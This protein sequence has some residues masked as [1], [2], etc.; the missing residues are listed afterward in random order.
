MRVF[1]WQADAGTAY[2]RLRLPLTELAARGH[3]AMVAERMPDGVQFAAGADVVVASRTC[4]PGPSA[5]FQ[6][7]AAEDRMLCVFE[8]D[9]DLFAVTPD[10][11]AHDY[12]HR[13]RHQQLVPV[14]LNEVAVG[15]VEV[16]RLAHTRD[17]LA[18]A[19]LVTTST[20]HL[21]GVLRQCTDAPVVVLPNRVPRW[22]T[23]LPMPVAH[24]GRL[25]YAHTGGV[26]HHRDFGEIAKTL[27]A[28]LQRH[29]DLVEF[30]AYG[31]DS[32]SR[33]SSIRGRTRHVPWQGS[34]DSYLRSLAGVDVGLA[35]LRETPFNHSKSALK[36]ME[37]G[38]LGVPVIAS[39]V[40]PYAEYVWHGVTGFLCS[41][42]REWREALDALMDQGL[43]LAMGAAG[44]EQAREHLVED[45]AHEWLDAYTARGKAAAA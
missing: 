45:H 41:T 13:V 28:H 5:T 42:A 12:F 26:S 36:V 9:D 43:R 29:G 18:A 23:E 10:N 35:P 38:A 25:V 44:R 24:D 17:N 39:N 7:L 15:E 27:R 32:T 6:R 4:N 8:T 30:A 1:G 2:W 19:H 3:E 20:E 37:F 16:D 33:V 22:L 34:V 11:A 21:A 31:F 40:G 14:G